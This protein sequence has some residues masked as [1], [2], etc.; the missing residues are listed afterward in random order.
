MAEMTLLIC[1]VAFH[2]LWGNLQ[3]PFEPLNELYVSDRKQ[4]QRLSALGIYTA[5]PHFS[6]PSLVSLTFLRAVPKLQVVSLYPFQTFQTIQELLQHV[7]S[8][9]LRQSRYPAR[10]LS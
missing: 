7:P 10:R 5:L 8:I 4:W 2:Q 9:Q 3:S 6:L 1:V